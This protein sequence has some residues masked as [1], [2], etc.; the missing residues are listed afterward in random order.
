MP[1]WYAELTLPVS[2]FAPSDCMNWRPAERRYGAV[3][4]AWIGYVSCRTHTLLREL[5]VQW[6]SKAKP[7]LSF[8]Y[9]TSALCSVRHRHQG[10]S[11]PQAV[12]DGQNLFRYVESLTGLGLGSRRRRSAKRNGHNRR[13]LQGSSPARMV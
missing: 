9:P 4:V 6:N 12:A 11:I 5:P 8:H 10:V 7:Q 3:F 2:L 13:N 1:S